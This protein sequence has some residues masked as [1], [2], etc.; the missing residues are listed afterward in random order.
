[1]AKKQNDMSVKMTFD[2]LKRNFISLSFYPVRYQSNFVIVRK[3]SVLVKSQ[4]PLT[5]NMFFFTLHLHYCMCCLCHY[6][7]NKLLKATVHWS[8]CTCAF[9]PN[10]KK[11]SLKVFLNAR[12]GEMWGQIFFRTSEILLVQPLVRGDNCTHSFKVIYH[13]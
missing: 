4:W 11:K 8:M 3:K 1:M 9:V 2:C 5:S 10:L 12:M 13:V 7:I 6:F